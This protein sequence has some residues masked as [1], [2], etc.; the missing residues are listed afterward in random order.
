MSFA[1]RLI[2]EQTLR[3][4]KMTYLANDGLHVLWWHALAIRLLQIV[5]AAVVIVL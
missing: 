2:L 4:M 3:S 1:S 5:S